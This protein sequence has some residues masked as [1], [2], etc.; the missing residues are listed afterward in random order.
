MSHVNPD[1]YVVIQG[2]MLTDLGL[3]GTDLMLYAI[4]F[5]FSQ[6]N[7]SQA[8]AGSLQY[9]ADWTNTTRRTVISS[10]NT[11]VRNGLITKHEETTNGVRFCEYRVADFTP[12]E[13]ISQGGV[14]IFHGGDV[15]K[16]HGGCEKISPNNIA[17]NIDIDNLERKTYKSSLREDMSHTAWDYQICITE[18]NSLS[19][20]GIP[21]IKDIKP[22]TERGRL[23]AK[24]SKQYSMD[25]YRTAIENIRESTFLQG[26]NDKGWTVTFDWF[27]KPNNFAKVLEGNYGNRVAPEVN[28]RQKTEEQ[29]HQEYMNMWRDL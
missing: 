7:D 17:D 6:G 25:D 15:K 21:A 23:V 13:K 28:A 16:F 29:K 27:I 19:G 18:W 11:L 8:Y 12:Y 14:K 5:G 10:L 1:N 20:Y 2:W 22:D 4:I 24:R 3:K 9:L 26:V